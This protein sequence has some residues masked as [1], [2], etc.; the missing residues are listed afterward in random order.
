MTHPSLVQPLP[1]DLALALASRSDRL[2]RLGS[3]LLFFSTVGS[4]NDVAAALAQ[5]GGHEG[6]VVIANAQT[7]G[8]GRQGRTWYSP[9]ADGLYVSV[10]LTPGRARAAGRAVSLLTIA[11]GVSLAEAID[12]ATGLRVD[13]K[14]PNDLLVG[15]RKL[16]GVL[17]EAVATP[18][19]S[20]AVGSVVL[21]YGLNVG[22]AVYP[23]HLQ[24]RATSLEAEL[25][26]AVDR[27]GLCA[28]TLASLARRYDDLLEG[29]FDAI[30]DLW[31]A[32]AP[33][34]VGARVSWSTP[35]GTESGITSGLDSMGALLVRVG[36]RIE[37]IVAGEVVWE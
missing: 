17:A 3:S 35:R 34:H 36:D 33:G 22:V 11:A 19:V 21:G 14:W 8:R 28:E 2:G 12:A 9:P 13:I 30:L 15:R 6:A 29:R 27:A 7:E 37:R 20:P 5:R 4:T 16:G 24:H 23:Q 10:V 25:G 32:R 18:G 1:A 26:R 31:R